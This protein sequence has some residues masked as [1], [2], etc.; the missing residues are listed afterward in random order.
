MLGFEI[1]MGLAR[2]WSETVLRC[3][4]AAATM[5]AETLAGSARPDTPAPPGPLA[6]EDRPINWLFLGSA[7]PPRSWYRPPPSSGPWGA[8]LGMI[9]AFPFAWGLPGSAVPGMASVGTGF[10]PFDMA[11]ALRA[12][13]DLYASP[14]VRMMWWPLLAGQSV[15]PAPWWW[16]GQGS[17]PAA[18]GSLPFTAYRS[19]GGHAVAQIAF[20]NDVVASIAVPAPALGAFFRW[21]L[22]AG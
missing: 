12:W 10:Q 9:G 22:G 18:T 5:A 20:P 3:A 1:Q 13:M 11:H 4:A 19:H 17:A 2:A 7:E 14:S 16:S 8:W 15:F 21:P 6:P